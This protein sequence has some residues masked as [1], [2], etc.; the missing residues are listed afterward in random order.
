MHPDLSQEDERYWRDWYELPAKDE[1]LH[2]TF[3][4][5]GRAF[6]DFPGEK[7]I[8]RLHQL[9]VTV[10]ASELIHLTSGL[11]VFNSHP[12]IH[13]TPAEAKRVEQLSS[14]AK[15]LSDLL[16]EEKEEWLSVWGDIADHDDEPEPEASVEVAALIENLE[17]LQQSSQERAAWLV[18]AKGSEIEPG[19]NR[20]PRIRYFYWL[21][22]LGFWK[23]VLGRPIA[24]S[25][26]DTAAYGP[27]VAFIRI[28][29]ERGVS[30]EDLTGD[31][32]RAFIRRVDEQGRIEMVK[33]YFGK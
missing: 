33:K 7:A 24:T 29:S 18:S 31:A 15:Q 27:L 14:L 26:S 6:K 2:A 30:Q 1:V 9:G 12:N 25:T 10:P 32:I 16:R 28:M 8:A 17:I 19:S 5:L 22:L 3:A 13:Y 20:A 21:M 23:F 11:A 4:T